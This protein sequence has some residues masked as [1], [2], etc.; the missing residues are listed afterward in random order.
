MTSRT[1]C[2][3]D[4]ALA[5]GIEAG[6]V[7]GI[8]TGGPR[9]DLALV[10]RGRVLAESFDSVASHGAQL[11]DAVEAILNSAGLAPKDIK[12]IAIGTGPGSFTGLRIGLSYAK[13][14]K[15]ATGCALVGIASLDTLALAA[16][17]EAPAPSGQLISAVLDARKGEVY[18]ALYRATANGLEKLSDDLVMTLDSLASRIGSDVLLVGDTKAKEACALAL[19]AGGGARCVELA[20]LRLRGRVVAALGAARLAA[21]DTDNAFMLE[22]LYVRAPEATFRA[23]PQ[24]SGAMV[25]G[26]EGRRTDPSVRDHR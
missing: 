14:L 23:G 26:A 25:N 5:S 4:A 21:G 11:P 17:F 18:A 22:P 3:V 12:A 1:L 6:P 10:A 2:T 19:R 9:A 15:M 13:G 7:L 8:D 20:E 16:L 24:T